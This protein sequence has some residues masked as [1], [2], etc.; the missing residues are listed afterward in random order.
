MQNSTIQR[1]NAE[2]EV[3]KST[4]PKMIAKAELLRALRKDNGLTQQELAKRL[5][6]SRE[7]VV[8]I[9]NNHRQQIENILASTEKK[10]WE[11]CRSQAKP[12]TRESFR[13]FV[14]S[15]FKF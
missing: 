6:L 8:G 7:T 5:G 9:E 13:D 4:D 2:S 1:T 12:E 11:V 15:W 3:E 14:L 10:W